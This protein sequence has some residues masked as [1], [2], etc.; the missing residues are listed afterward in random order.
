MG[1]GQWAKQLEP[2]VAAKAMF[3]WDKKIS[4]FEEDKN[5]IKNNFLAFP[6]P[7]PYS[8]IL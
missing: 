5:K 2:K 4:K 3:P 6:N 1:N 8:I 7:A